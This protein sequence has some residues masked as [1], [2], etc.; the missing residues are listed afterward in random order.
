MEVWKDIIGYNGLYLVSNLGRVKSL[1]RKRRTP[2]NIPYISKEKFLKNNPDNR[3][4]PRVMLTSNNKGKYHSLHRLLAIHF[5]PNPENKPQ[6][7][8]INGIKIDN[9]LENLEWC[10]GKENTKHA[11]DIGLHPTRKGEKNAMSKLTENQVLQIRERL[12]KGETQL[13]I[14]ISHNVTRQTI[15]H[16]KNNKTW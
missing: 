2:N 5:I 16:I 8:H 4:Y 12:K 10:T 9:R 14:A 11:H 15:S 3:G 1:P 13:S 6:V 7:N